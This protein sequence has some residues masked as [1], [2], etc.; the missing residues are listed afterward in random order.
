METAIYRLGALR[1]ASDFPLFGLPRSDDE[2]NSEVV[3]RRAHIP[4]DVAS[5]TA[6]FVGGEYSGTYNGREI[7]IVSPH[8]GRFLVRAGEEI[9]IDKAPSSDDENV[10]AY[11]VGAVFGVL[12][13]QRGI[14][15]LHASS[16]DVV[17]GC[18]V[19]VGPSGAGKST[20]V[21]ALSR[22]GHEIIGD[23]Q[24]FLQLDNYGNVQAWPGISRIR[25]REDART[26]LRFNDPAIEREM[27]GRNKY[28]IPVRAPR[29]PI[30]ARPLRGVYQLH[31]VADGA[32]K[33]T[34]VQGA[35]AVE[36]LMQNVYPPG[37]AACLG[38][39]PR[40]FNLCAAAARDLLVFR[41]SRPWSLH[42]LEQ[43]VELLESHFL[44]I[45]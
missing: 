31:R 19:F 42:A 27:R 17:D 18:A 32:A 10:R 43:G 6:R 9:L 24:C 14:T 2:T 39:Q 21:A 34:R 3:I 29:N 23:D 16:V 38:Y 1:V 26:A 13:L 35:D 4:D 36:V 37:A 11:L 22:R 44:S 15:P 25:L 45:A 7:L 30:Q 8:I 33:L 41:L 5:T 12:C 20:L 40:V 28:I